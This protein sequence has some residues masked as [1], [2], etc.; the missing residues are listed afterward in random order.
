VNS[1]PLNVPDKTELLATRQH[2]A[3]PITAAARRAA[4]LLRFECL[5]IRDLTLRGIRVQNQDLE[6]AGSQAWEQQTCNRHK[7]KPAVVLGV[8]KHNASFRRICLE[9]LHGD[10]HELCADSLTLMCWDHGKWSQAKPG[11]IPLADLNGRNR[12][13]ADD[14]PFGFSNKRHRERV[15][16]P[17]FTD[18][19]LL[20]VVRMG[21]TF[22]RFNGDKLYGSFIA[23]FFRPNVCEHDDGWFARLR[24]W[25]FYQV[26]TL[27]T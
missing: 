21:R 17:Q 10:L 1:D 24:L 8:S 15:G 13:M 25:S 22:E 7:T 12:N 27:C 3:V 9:R 23:W 20:R 5:V 19:E 14:L 16:P 2:L 11:V 6:M 4:L 26:Q 18:D